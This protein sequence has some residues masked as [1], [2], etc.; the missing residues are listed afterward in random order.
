MIAPCD[1]EICTSTCILTVSLSVRP[2]LGLL[3]MF[4]FSDILAMSL[5]PIHWSV[6]VSQNATNQST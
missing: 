6:R 3:L 4:P 5:I 2:L 1:D